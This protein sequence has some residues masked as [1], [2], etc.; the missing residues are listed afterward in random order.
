ML[1]RIDIDGQEVRG[2]TGVTFLVTPKGEAELTL[3]LVAD[4]EIEGQA[5]VIRH[6]RRALSWPDR[7]RLLFRSAGL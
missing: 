7:V 1:S 5:D 3:R 6:W 4:I 2:V